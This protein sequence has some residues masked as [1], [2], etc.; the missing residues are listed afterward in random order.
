M[1]EKSVS[2]RKKEENFN[3]HSKIANEEDIYDIEDEDEE[4]ENSDSNEYDEE[5]DDEDEIEIHE[6]FLEHEDE[7]L[8]VDKKIE[9]QSEDENSE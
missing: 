5:D 8:L 2:L 6:N 9:F 3:L 7:N 4:D 1:D